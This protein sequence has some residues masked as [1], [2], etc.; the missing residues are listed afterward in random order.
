MLHLKKGEPVLLA[1]ASTSIKPDDLRIGAVD[2]AGPLNTYGLH[3]EAA[4]RAGVRAG[5]TVRA[6]KEGIYRLKASYAKLGNGPALEHKSREP[7]IGF[8]TDPKGTVTWNLELRTPGRYEVVLRAA[9]PVAN[10]TLAIE[11]AKQRLTWTSKSTGEW[12]TF[13]EFVAGVLEFPAAGPQRLTM[14]SADGKGPML[15]LQHL[16]LRPAKQLGPTSQRTKRE[17]PG[18]AYQEPEF[19]PGAKAPTFYEESMK[20]RDARVKWWVDGRFGCFMHWGVYSQ[21]G[22]VWKGEAVSGYSEHIQRKRKIDQATYASEVAAKF[23]PVGFDAEEWVQLI[24]AA[25]MRYL[26]ITAKHHDGFAMWDSK[27]SDWNIMK[28]TPFGRDPMA[29]LRDACRKHGIRFGF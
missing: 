20:T 13:E 27:A 29:E 5:E 18:D 2:P 3:G 11:G 24:K 7:T 15:N 22:G 28:A 21:L 26:V 17:A 19:A 9:T 6:D 25:G 23:N 4:E 16:V 1:S 12:D 10:R 14:R 8:W